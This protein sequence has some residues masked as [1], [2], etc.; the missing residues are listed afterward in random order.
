MPLDAAPARSAAIVEVESLSVRFV[1]RD[2][3]V[4]VV[5]DVSFTLAAAEVL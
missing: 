1:T 5:R 3:D 4:S 2:A